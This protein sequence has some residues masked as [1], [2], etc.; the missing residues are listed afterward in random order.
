MKAAAPSRNRAVFFDRDGVLNP[1]QGYICSPEALHAYPE[2]AEAVRRVNRSGW[3]A[4]VV[5]NQA[6]VARGLLD[7]ATLGRI[8]AR[9]EAELGQGGARLDGIYYC[10]HHPEAGEPPYRQACECRKPRPGMLR[11]AAREHRLR[12]S[13]CWLITDRLGEVEMMQREGG[14][15]ALVLTG[16]GQGELDAQAAHGGGPRADL[17]SPGVLPAVEAILHSRGGELPAADPAPAAVEPA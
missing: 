13:D 15:A 17:V 9:L 16:Y 11:R 3:L 7:E 14:R 8:H 2:A 4:L 10:P 1:E 6:G 5:T 12:L